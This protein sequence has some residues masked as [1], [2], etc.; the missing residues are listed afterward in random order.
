MA[1]P[2]FELTGFLHPGETF[3]MARVNIIS[4]QDLSLHTHNYAELLWIEKGS[5][6]HHVNGERL[7][8]EVG[9]LF[10][11]RSQDTHTY[12]TSNKGEG[13]TLINIAFPVETLLHFKHRY[14]PDSNHYFWTTGEMPYRIQLPPELLHRLSSRAEETMGRGRNNLELDSLL[15]FVF[16]QITKYE[17]LTT[18]TFMPTWLTNAIQEY[19]SPTFFRQGCSGFA[20]LCNRNSDYVN[21]TV[22]HHFNKSLTELINE[23]KMRYAATQLIITSMPIKEISSN[24]GFSNLGHFYK[25]FKGLYGLTPKRYRHIN[26]TMF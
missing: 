8:I 25:I 1:V 20:A 22:Q 2:V 17:D 13:I 16:R 10:M 19:N 14:F 12:S 18:P 3:H 9:D 11:I 5:G 4:K 7:R 21:R 15:L 23:L 6:Y 24:C 26:Q